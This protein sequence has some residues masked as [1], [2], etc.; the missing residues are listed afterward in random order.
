MICKSIDALVKEIK[1]LREIEERREAKEGLWEWT[2]GFLGE[3][4]M[5]DRPA[6][7]TGRT[8]E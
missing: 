4:R 2:P 3:T 7:R 6:D 5:C 8:E 1:K